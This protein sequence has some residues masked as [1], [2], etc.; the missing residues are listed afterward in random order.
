[1]RG[2][3]AFLAL[4]AGG[5]LVATAGRGRAASAP[6]DE[7]VV[8]K[9]DIVFYAARAARD[10]QGA[11]DLAQ[12]AGLLLQ[13]GRE[14][15][16]PRDFRL[17]EATARRS[18]ARR[19][20]RNGKA[21]LTLAS[22]L[23]A[24]HRFVEARAVAE[25]LVARWPEPEGYRALLGEIQL[26]LGDYDGAGRT[27]AGLAGARRHLAVAPRLARW[28]EL[29]GRVEEARRLL[30]DARAEAFRRR[31]LPREQVAWFQLRVGDLELRHGRLADAERALRDGLAVVPD[32]PRLLAALARVAAA[33][34]RWREV[35]T[36]GER[37]GSGA[38]IATLALVGDA[39]AE[40][41]DTVR[42]AL[43]YAR[44][45]R[46]AAERPEPFNRQWTQFRLDHR[47][48]VSQTRALLEQEVRIRPDVY[49]WDLVGWARYL[50]GDVAGASDAIGRALRV[51]TRDA[52]L[53]RH[54]AV[55]ARAE[56]GSGS[57][58]LLPCDARDE[59]PL[60][61]DTPPD[62]SLRARR[63]LPSQRDP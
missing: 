56:A 58:A 36:Y 35:V 13:R 12:L 10:P 20:G 17:A 53:F 37:A 63:R 26:E 18:L 11:A 46:L 1:V 62:R 60:P 50:D 38:D 49:G 61:L 4:L 39:Y 9:R 33:R 22:S 29:H 14:T 32:D 19:A 42:A 59:S 24:Q 6:L 45:E 8:R 54:A 28:A 27:F 21:Y 5:V 34:G 2:I 15:G 31:D 43:W 23:L 57:A 47:R 41:V 16:D 55:I 3:P 48:A 51:G 30:E 25:T 52:A 44:A 40:L 7:R